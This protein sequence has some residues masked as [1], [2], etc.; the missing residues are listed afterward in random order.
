MPLILQVP[1]ILC[2]KLI[3]GIDPI[4]VQDSRVYHFYCRYPQGVANE[5]N[6]VLACVDADIGSVDKG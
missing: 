4:T 3:L 1:C 6:S 5:T 2:Q